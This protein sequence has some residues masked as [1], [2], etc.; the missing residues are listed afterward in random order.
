MTNFKVCPKCE[1]YIPNNA[2]PGAYPGALSRVD[3]KTEI[4]SECGI[5]EALDDYIRLNNTP[6]AA[7]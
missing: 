2:T 4:C 3:N 7:V 5:L 1:G 6:N